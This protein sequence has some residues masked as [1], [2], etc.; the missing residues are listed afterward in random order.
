[1]FRLPSGDSRQAVA[2]APDLAGDPSARERGMAMSEGYSR[3]RSSNA[4]DAGI[5]QNASPTSSLPRAHCPLQSQRHAVRKIVGRSP[6][7]HFQP[8]LFRARVASATSRAG[9]PGRRSPS[10]ALIVH[11]V[12]ERAVWIT[13]LTEN[14]SPVP[15]L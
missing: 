4:S 13:S 1:M 6:C 14:P 15:R 3:T 2:D 5:V 9:S 12:T 8:R 7:L 10:R 11:P